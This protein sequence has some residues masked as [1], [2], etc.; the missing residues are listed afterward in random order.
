M[1]RILIKPVVT[2]CIV[3]T[4]ISA[5][6]LCDAKH[7]DSTWLAGVASMV[8]TPEQSMWMAGYAAREHPA[9]GTMHDLWAK[10]LALEDAEGKKAILITTDLLGF[11]KALSDQIRD[12]LESEFQL[13]RARIILNSTHSH[14]GPVLKDALYDIYPL[15]QQQISDIEHY[16]DWLADQLVVLVGEALNSLEPVHIYAQNG[17]TRFQVN[18]RNNDAS[19]LSTLTELKGPNDHAVP[20]IK[21]VDKQGDLMAVTFGYACHPTVLDQYEWSGDYPGFAQIALEES[22]PGA[23][24]LFFAGAGADQNPLPRR[25]VG[26]ARQYGM[27]LAAAVE[28]VLEEDMQEL[29]PQLSASYSEIELPLNPPH[30]KDELLEIAHDTSDYA[31]YQKRWA[32]NM[33]D[34]Y[35]RNES[36]ISSYPYPL[37]VWQLGEQ[38]VVNMGGEVV[39]GYA[40]KIKQIF[41]PETFVI[42]YSNDVMGYIPTVT[43]L[44]EGGYEGY[45]SQQVYG[46]P[47]TWKPEIESMIIQEV[48]RLAEQS[49]VPQPVGMKTE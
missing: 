43:I 42:A 20:V 12:Q 14:S 48:E 3:L 18:R 2:I 39:V 33:L 35:E 45:V 31:S 9:E 41:G 28:R 21:V 34:K 27:E 26:L 25:S 10:A 37:Q 36:F 5:D 1:K 49:G 8:I 47:G 46:L 11:P 30:T 7:P 13:S 17:V 32:E 6:A 40:N 4:F 23:T 44:E 29:S 38:M 16:S 24:A 15:D 22:H 19:E